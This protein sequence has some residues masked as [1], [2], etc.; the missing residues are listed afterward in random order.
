M[1]S[2]PGR[3]ADGLDKNLTV[4]TG[5][6]KPGQTPTVRQVQYLTGLIEDFLT[7]IYLDLTSLCN[8]RTHGL[9]IILTR[10]YAVDYHYARGISKSHS[11]ARESRLNRYM[12]PFTIS[13]LQFIATK[14][15][16][17]RPKDFSLNL[18]S[19]YL[20]RNGGAQSPTVLEPDFMALGA[21]DAES[22]FH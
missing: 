9:I 22:K 13:N 8:L 1:A 18:S 2:K 3:G 17:L 19:V 14:S 20:Y 4:H 12:M 5:Q 11:E 15:R 21:A 10:A 16:Y 7:G 6:S